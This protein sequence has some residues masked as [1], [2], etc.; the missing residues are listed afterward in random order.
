MST[1]RAERCS[2]G[3][4]R[5]RSAKRG[6]SALGRLST[7]NQ[8]LSSRAR[9]T[10]VFPEPLSPVMIRIR[11][12]LRRSTR[13]R[14]AER[15]SR[16]PERRRGPTLALRG[17]RALIAP[18]GA[19]R[20]R[21]A[22]RGR[23]AGRGLG[24]D[25]PVHALDELARRIVPAFLQELVARGHLDQDGQVAA[26]RHRHADEGHLLLEDQELLVLEAQPI[27][28]PSRLPALQADHEL[29]AL[30]RADG[31]D[32]VEVL[33]VDD[34][35]PAQLHVMA[36]QVRRGPDEDVADAADLHH[37]VRDQ[38]VAAVDE[39]QGTF[40]LADPALPHDQDAQAEDV[41]QDGVEVEAQ[42]QPLLQEGGESLDE[43]SGLRRRDQDRD[44]PRFRFRRQ[45]GGGVQALG[46]HE[47]R[48]A[49]GGQALQHGG[50][51]RR[52]QLAQVSELAGAEDLHP[53]VADVIRVP[54]EGE[55]RTLDA[56]EG[57]DLIEAGRPRHQPQP[58]CGGGLEQLAHLH[59]RPFAR[60]LSALQLQRRPTARRA[61]GRSQAS[62]S[63]S[64][65]LPSFRL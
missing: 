40:R 44:A 37:V 52:R 27:V 3:L 4:S 21:V 48:D 65:R 35:Q 12:S 23:D 20:G 33:D 30:R 28:L 56:G 47:A 18:S 17:A 49:A 55:A 39:V 13:R 6:M 38:P 41:D 45:L 60:L 57:D 14:A 7:Q 8:P 16:P 10:C 62:G 53:A 64:P 46:H 58:Q 15:R 24:L 51:A 29:H 63:M 34:P 19:R 54:G 61:R 5:M 9:A 59:L 42:G 50:A 36:G 32:A 11:G 31:G 25:H 22:A 43:R 1:T 26:R 2:S